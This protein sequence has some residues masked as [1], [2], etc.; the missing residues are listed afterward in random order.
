MIA[1]DT[2]ILVY[3]FMKHSPWHE[4]ARK[5]IQELAEGDQSWAIPWPCYH[6]FI[7]VVTHPK[8]YTPSASIDNA[9]EYLDILRKSRSLKTI[10]EG[11]GFYEK[12]KTMALKAN[13]KGGKIH[14]CRIAAI[15]EN[16]GVNLLYSSDKDFSLFPKL[17]CVNPL[18][19]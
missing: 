9:I 13:L 11:P 19:Q 3:A 15:C 2:N 16:H 12:M 4:A 6:E 10:G 5:C 14:D 17:K 8:I 7:G 18:I 1:L